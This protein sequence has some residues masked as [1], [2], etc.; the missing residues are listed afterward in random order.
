MDCAEQIIRLSPQLHYQLPNLNVTMPFN[1]RVK[2]VNYTCKKKI[3]V[4][5][6]VGG[7]GGLRV[8]LRTVINVSRVD[9]V[10]LASLTDFIWFL[11]I[12]MIYTD[13]HD[14]WFKVKPTLWSLWLL[15]FT[16]IT[17]LLWY[18]L[19]VQ[20]SHVN[21]I[22]NIKMA[23]LILSLHIMSI[24]MWFYRTNPVVHVVYIHIVMT[25]KSVMTFNCVNKTSIHLL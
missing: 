10:W 24:Y 22:I 23:S 16:H 7:G 25:N 3:C 8:W 9:H 20:K 13:I 2:M 21:F 18:I 12:Y 6:C 4:C 17:N 15:L 1:L 11:Q 19:I 5:V 14:I